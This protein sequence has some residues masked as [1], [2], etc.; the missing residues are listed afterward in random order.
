MKF[1]NA[2]DRWVSF[3]RWFLYLSFSAKFYCRRTQENYY[4]QKDDGE[5]ENAYTK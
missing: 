2:I 4:Q 5:K 3:S 1:E